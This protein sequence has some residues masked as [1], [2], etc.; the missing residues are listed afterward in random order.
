MF[1]APIIYYWIEILYPRYIWRLRILAGNIKLVKAKLVQEYIDTAEVIGRN[2][3]F[4]TIEAV[5]DSFPAPKLSH[6]SSKDP[7]SQAGAVAVLK[8]IQYNE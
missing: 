2:I 5:T 8:M 1:H 6:L 7:E 3:N 4:L